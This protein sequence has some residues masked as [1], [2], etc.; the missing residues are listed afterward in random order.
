MELIKTEKKIHIKVNK[1]A[2]NSRV[3]NVWGQTSI[4][5]SDAIFEVQT[6]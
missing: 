3:A 1:S 2:E 5:R 6:E 4:T